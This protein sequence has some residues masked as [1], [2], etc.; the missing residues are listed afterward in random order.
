[1]EAIKNIEKLGMNLS[2]VDKAKLTIGAL[3]HKKNSNISFKVVD[4]DFGNYPAGVMKATIKTEQGKSLSENYATKESLIDLTRDMFGKFL[5]KAII[6]VQPVTYSPA[7]IE[8]VDPEWIKEK[9]LKKGV[10]IKDIVT[11]TGIDK[12]NLSAWINGIRPMS[13]PVKAMFYFYLTR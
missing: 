8:V 13:Q 6:H 2:E 9:M 11:D 1:M 3:L 10:R 5:G 12:T 4:V 7:I